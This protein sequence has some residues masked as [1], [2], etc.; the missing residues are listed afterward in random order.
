MHKTE[1]LEWF[2]AQTETVRGFTH[3]IYSGL[4][5][6]ELSCV[7]EMILTKRPDASGLYHVSSEPISKFELL[8]MI[9]EK[10][11]MNIHIIPDDHFRCDRS[12]NSSKF[13]R[14]FGYTPPSWKEMIEELCRYLKEE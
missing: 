7:V 10:M 11:S 6:L 2:I 9:L 8:Q 1:L 13:R 14:E 3:A 5:T 12:L 4:T